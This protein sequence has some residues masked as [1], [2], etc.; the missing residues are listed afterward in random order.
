LTYDRKKEN[1]RKVQLSKH[2]QNLKHSMQSDTC[3]VIVA[4]AVGL[5]CATL[6]IVG[7]WK[8]EVDTTNELS[9]NGVWKA[10]TNQ[11]HY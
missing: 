3:A 1:C 10:G 6:S 8:D 5:L 2:K 4:H 7:A 11:D 9:E